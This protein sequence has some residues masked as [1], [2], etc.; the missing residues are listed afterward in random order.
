MHE[1]SVVGVRIKLDDSVRYVARD[2]EG[3][4]CVFDTPED[5]CNW[6]FGWDLQ[7][8]QPDALDE[9]S[10]DEALKMLALVFKIERD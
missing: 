5:A 10:L 7:P 1:P 4:R 3:V 8:A 6:A 9:A 2:S